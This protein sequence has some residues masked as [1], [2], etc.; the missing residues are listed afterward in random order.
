MATDE[1]GVNVVPV[2][3]SR[4]IDGP[5]EIDDPTSA[6]AE[7]VDQSGIEILDLDI[8]FF[9]LVQSLTDRLDALSDTTFATRNF[10]GVTISPH[11]GRKFV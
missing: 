10:R 3:D 8:E 2:G 11:F 9:D 7:K 6:Q 4:L 1:T 5:A